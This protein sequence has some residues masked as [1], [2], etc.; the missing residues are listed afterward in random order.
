MPKSFDQPVAVSD[1]HGASSASGRA[2]AARPGRAFAQ[3]A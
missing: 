2:E 3:A 1:A